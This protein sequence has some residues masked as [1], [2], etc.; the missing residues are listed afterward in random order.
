MSDIEAVK[1]RL[2]N[3]YKG[4]LYIVIDIACHTETS[5][6]I[7]IYRNIGDDKVWASPIDMFE[8][9]IMVDGGLVDRFERLVRDSYTE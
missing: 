2:Y 7:V 1:N 6:V 9:Q 4:K 5:E 3:H 8:E